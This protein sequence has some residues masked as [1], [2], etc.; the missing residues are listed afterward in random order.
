MSKPNRDLHFPL[1]SIER[2]G[3][4]LAEAATTTGTAVIQAGYDS[5]R[6]SP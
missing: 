3:I 1:L 6:T 5:P 4:L 2:M